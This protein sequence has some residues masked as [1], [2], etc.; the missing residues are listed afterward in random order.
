MNPIFTIGHS[1]HPI[2]TFLDLLNAHRIGV[3][4]DVRSSPWSKRFPHFSSRPLADALRNAG[5]R[6]VLL[7][8][9]LGGRPSASVRMQMNGQGYAAMAATPAF[10]SG[11]VRLLKGRSEHRIALMCA[12]RDPA[13]CHRALLVGR[14]LARRDAP[15]DHLHPDG[16]VESHRQLEQRLLEMAGLGA[17]GDLFTS[18]DDLLDLAYLE[19]ERRAAAQAHAPEES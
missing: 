19:H 13:M 8:H 3:L 17:G 9:V 10:E 16:L 4:V 15:P 6:Y 2:E 11:I 12:E 7:G 5:I 1:D 18:A 14:A